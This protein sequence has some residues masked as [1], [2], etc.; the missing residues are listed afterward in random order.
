MEKIPFLFYFENFKRR[1]SVN[2][3]IRRQREIVE[4]EF[5]ERKKNTKKIQIVMDIIGKVFFLPLWLF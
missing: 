3:R 2:L 5:L 1:L 4:T